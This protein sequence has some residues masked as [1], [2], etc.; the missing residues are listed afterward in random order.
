MRAPGAAGVV[1]GVLACLFIG[2]AGSGGS[3]GGS[4][5]GGNKPPACTSQVPGDPISY[6][7]NIAPILAQ[8]CGLSGCHVPPIVNADLDLTPAKAYDQMV[9]VAASQVARLKRIKPGDPDNSYLLRKI[10]PGSQISGVFMP[11][12]CPGTPVAGPRCLLPDEIDAFR[13]WIAE[14]APRN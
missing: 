11:Q 4:G 5:G 2:C 12:G 3:S 10:T 6:Q 9:N 13:T 14:C 1:V 8:S 7:S